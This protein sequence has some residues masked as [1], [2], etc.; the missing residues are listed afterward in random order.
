MEYVTGELGADA[1]INY[2][3]TEN[4]VEAIAHHSPEGVDIYYD[5]VGGNQLDAALA[6]MNKFGRIVGCGAISGYNDTVTPINNYA[7]I[8]IKSLEYIG[9]VIDNYVPRFPEGFAKLGEW[10]QSGQIKYRHHFIDGLENFPDAMKQIF[11]GV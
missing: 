8:I 10:L 1:C 2:K 11:S 7:S 3:T 9:F 5:N 4:L 6:L